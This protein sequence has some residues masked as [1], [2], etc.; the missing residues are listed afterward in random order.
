M[1]TLYLIASI[2][3]QRVALP[4]EAVESV[5]EVED[6]TPVPLVAPHVSGLFALRSRVLTIIDPLA[7]LGLGRHRLEG[8]MQAVIVE[9]DGHP[10]GLL[11]EEVEDVVTAGAVVPSRSP[12]GRGWSRASLGMIEH[13][14]RSLLLL[15][16]AV[17]VAGVSSQAA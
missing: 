11:V 5:V 17:L 8:Q 3:G 13:D 7:A 15:D 9:C 6:I 14:G 16:P 2:A 12:L 1:E 4:A 10:Y